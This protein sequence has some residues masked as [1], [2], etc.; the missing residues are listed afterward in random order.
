VLRP[1]VGQRAAPPAEISTID[2]GAE[3]PRRQPTH[4]ELWPPEPFPVHLQ[5]TPEPEGDKVVQED[6]QRWCRMYA[7]KHSVRVRHVPSL[8]LRWRQLRFRF[9]RGD[10]A[11]A[12]EIERLVRMA[13]PLKR[14]CTPAN[15]HHIAQKCRDY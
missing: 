15:V 11:A 13:V 10:K 14:D 5:G 3:P 9:I 8:S 2:A 4:D 7:R 6:A 1:D 12:C